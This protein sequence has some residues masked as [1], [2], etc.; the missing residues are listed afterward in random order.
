LIDY[1]QSLL[2]A[3]RQSPDLR[4]GLSPRAG[5][6]LLAAAR[7]W[8]L[9]DGRDYALPED[10]QAVFPHVA[11]HRLRIAGEERPVPAET[12]RALIQS[13]KLD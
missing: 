12:L 4:N 5:L 9:T 3:S 7:A 13:V 8:A 2:A 1:T 11:G 6:G 10:L